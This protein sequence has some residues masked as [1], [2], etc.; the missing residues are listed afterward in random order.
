MS[1]GASATT[2]THEFVDFAPDELVEG[3]LYI[4]IRFAMAMHKCA[5][6]CGTEVTTPLH[7][8]GWEL[9]FNG[10]SVSLYPSIGN[11]SL[12]CRSHYWIWRGTVEWARSWS[13]QDVAAHRARERVRRDDYYA[14]GIVPAHAGRRDDDDDDDDAGSQEQEK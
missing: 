12:P 11:W 2:V 9:T 7:P 1:E 14:Y 4:S 6:G 5:C 8:T 10:E 3:V 13:T